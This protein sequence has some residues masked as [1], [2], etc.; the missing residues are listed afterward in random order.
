MASKYDIFIS[1]R[2]DG[3]AQYARILQLMLTQRGYRVFLDYDELKDGV[4][5]NHIKEAIA[6]APIFML[7]LS[8][9]ALER[10]TNEGDW[11]RQEIMLAAQKNKHIIPVNPDNTFDGIPDGVPSEVAI[12]AGSH[13]HSEIPFGQTLGI[14]V[15][16]M[17]KNRIMPIIGVRS[18]EHHMDEDYDTARETL[19]KL[20]ARNKFIKCS[21]ITA[22]LAI[23]LVV[24]GACYISFRN[25]KL[26]ELRKDI[27]N[28]YKEFGLTLSSDLSK[29]QILTI[30][31]ILRNM[32]VVTEDSLWISKYEFTVGWWYGILGERY[33]KD[34]KD[35]PMTN[36]SFGE[37][38]L[39]FL[40]YL[41]DIT[42]IEF[43][44]PSV[45]EWRFAAH[46]AAK[47]EEYIYVGSNDV[48]KVAWYEENSGGHLHPSN[49]HTGKDPN[50]I[51]LYDM[52]GNV[53]EIC[54]SRYYSTDSDDMFWVSCGGDYTSPASEVTTTSCKAISTDQKS[55]ALGFRLI[56]RNNQYWR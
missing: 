31:E 33:D 24:S 26:N 47:N 4:F 48:N 35:F 28:E 50:G 1:Y 32:H 23:I 21:V 36:I 10:C 34:L 13:Q 39:I 46:G 9:G 38:S 19:K 8:A 17:I 11:L 45:E 7:V 20:D 42:R 43:D 6:D 30:D 40:P 22:I 44:L 3:G 29:K 18:Q 52:S 5:S 37:I 54:N 14:T 27:Q 55:K 49:G 56:I 41:R 53:S 16:F 12:T 15:D 51:D 25:M 2:R